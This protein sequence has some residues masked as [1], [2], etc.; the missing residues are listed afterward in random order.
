MTRPIYEPSLTRTDAVLGYGSDQLFRR[1][2]PVNAYTIPGFHAYM[3]EDLV[4]TT[5]ND[6]RL[7]F[8]FWINDD[9]TVFEAGTLSG[10]DVTDVKLLLD[11]WYSV[12]CWA[13]FS[14]DPATGFAGI[15]MIHDDTD[16]SSPPEMQGV[17]YPVNFHTQGAMMFSQTS[18]YPPEFLTQEPPSFAWAD[19]L[20][21]WVVQNAGINR[22]ITWAYLV[23]AYLGP[24]D[25]T[26][27]SS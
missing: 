13:G 15:M 17:T 10:G 21:F 6:G 19:R 5:G 18:C 23:I 16:I 20:E 2:A 24:R 25:E 1:P 7:E 14:N 3:T 12:K 27:P 8:D 11:G 22:T 9:A 26:A 4:L